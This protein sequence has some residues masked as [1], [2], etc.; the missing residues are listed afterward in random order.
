METHWSYFFGFGLP[1]TIL[2]RSTSFF[3]GYGVFLAL[4]PFCIILG[5]TTD[6]TLAYRHNTFDAG[7]PKSE[8]QEHQEKQEKQEKQEQGLKKEEKHVSSSTSKIKEIRKETVMIPSL[9]VFWLAR[10]WTNSSVEYINKTNM[11]QRFLNRKRKP[12]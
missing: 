7:T 10:V 2:M 12:E 1:Y 9:A 6:F 11:V 5:S 3:V 8:K 4:F